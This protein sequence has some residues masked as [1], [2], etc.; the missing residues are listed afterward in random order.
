MEEEKLK[1]PVYE[2]MAY[3]LEVVNAS[4]FAKLMGVSSNWISCK[5]RCKVNKRG[6]RVQ[7]LPTDMEI[8]NNALPKLANEM[9]KRCLIPQEMYTDSDAMSMHIRQEVK[10]ILIP[11]RLAETRLG[12]DFMWLRTR[13]DVKKS[14]IRNT[15]KFTPQDAA[16]FNRAIKEIILYIRGVEM[17]YEPPKE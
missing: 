12:H 8:I 6:Y 11:K 2:G 17:V 13:L 5:Q 10:P 1:V 15:S 4:Y 16:D 3:L 7:Y 14:G 9:M